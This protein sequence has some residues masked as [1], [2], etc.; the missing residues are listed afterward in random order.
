M[1]CEYERFSV[2]WVP[3][4]G[5]AL[6]D[7]GAAWTGWC[8]VTGEPVAPR[9]AWRELREAAKV[10][11]YPG[12]QGLRMPLT[13]PFTLKEG[14]SRWALESML[15]EFAAQHASVHVARPVARIINDRVMFLPSEPNPQLN[16]LMPEL[17]DLVSSLGTPEPAPVPRRFA[18]PLTGV[19]A[20][21]VASRIQAVLKPH[22]DG[23]VGTS[24]MIASVSLMG[25]LGE[26]K[27][28]RMLDRYP[29]TGFAD[30]RADQPAGMA[31]A[32][33][34]LLAP[35]SGTDTRGNTEPQPV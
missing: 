30:P 14:I 15:E 3:V 10:A 2:A 18:L 7:F 4:P 33:P 5:T 16:R 13:A 26:G 9:P 6:A 8:P 27:A 35:I 1:D 22:L 19:V 34:D 25:D 24:P 31:C 17:H 12:R 28:W 11:H 23:I 21:R 32:G 20:P 29:L